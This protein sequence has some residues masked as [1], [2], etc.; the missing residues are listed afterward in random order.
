MFLCISRF[1]I[2]PFH[3]EQAS[4][5]ILAGRGD[6]IIR[7]AARLDE[8][9]FNLNGTVAVRTLLDKNTEAH[10]YARNLAGSEVRPVREP[11]AEFGC[12]G[13][14]GDKGGL[15]TPL[16]EYGIVSVGDKDITLL[17]DSYSVVG[18][19]DIKRAYE[20]ALPEVVRANA[21]DTFAPCFL[22]VGSET[23][24]G[25]FPTGFDCAGVEEYP[26]RIDLGGFIGHWRRIGIF[27][28][29]SE[30]VLGE[31]AFREHGCAGDEIAAKVDCSEGG[32]EGR[33]A[34]SS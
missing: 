30:D 32:D 24:V 19:R 11:F 27:V 2:V 29:P 13:N 8:F 3:L 6:Y 18:G 21:L 12:S 28:E 22:K 4:I 14:V 5:A 31:V 20:V 33:A 34:E 17:F 7:P 15:G 16:A 1:G 10:E 26:F 9:L 25:S 23:E